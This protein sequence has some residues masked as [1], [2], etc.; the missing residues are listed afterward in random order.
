MERSCHYCISWSPTVVNYNLKKN[1][2]VRHYSPGM[3]NVGEACS[4]VPA[5]EPRVKWSHLC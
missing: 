3:V 2:T 5:E 4:E 1:V